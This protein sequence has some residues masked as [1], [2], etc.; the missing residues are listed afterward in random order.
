MLSIHTCRYR[1]TCKITKCSGSENSICFI[2]F[3]DYLEGLVG[4]YSG[5]E[6]AKGRQIGL[7][8]DNSFES[9]SST[10]KY[11]SPHD[12]SAGLLEGERPR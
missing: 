10:W 7:A 8:K 1:L 3:L 5:R 4:G 2:C 9:G 12:A 11:L 6:G